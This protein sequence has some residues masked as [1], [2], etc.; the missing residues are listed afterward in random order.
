MGWGVGDVVHAR[1]R[2]LSVLGEGGMGRVWRARDLVLDREVAIKELLLSG[3]RLPGG[4]E[5]ELRTR[6]LREARSAAQLKHPGVITVHDVIDHEGDPLIVM[7]LIDG[8]SLAALLRAKG[9]LPAPRVAEI[10]TALLDALRAAHAHGIFH[11]DVKPSNV[12]FE[13]DRI[14]LT[15]FGIAFHPEDGRITRDGALLGTPAFMAPEQASGSPP[16]AAADLWSLGATLYHAV[17]GRPPVRGAQVM[18]ILSALSAPGEVPL[19]R[20]QMPE[21]LRALLVGLLRKD[22]AERITAAQASRLLEQAGGRRPPAPPAGTVPLPPP[23]AKRPGLPRWRGPLLSVGGIA[24]VV[25]LTFMLANVLPHDEPTARKQVPMQFALRLK[26][27]LRSKVFAPIAFSPSEETPLLAA[28]DGTEVRL[29]RL[30]D[31]EDFKLRPA[32]T[33]EYQGLAFDPSGRVLAAFGDDTDARVWDIANRTELGTFT[34]HD[35]SIDLGILGEGGAAVT[36]DV[37]D[38]A[39][40]WNWGTVLQTAN[41]DP[42]G[43]LLAVTLQG[44]ETAWA[45]FQD[46][47]DTV[48]IWDLASSTLVSRLRGHQDSVEKAEFSPDGKII[49]TASDDRTTRIWETGTGQ[50]WHELKT[51]ETV[52]LIRF[53]KDGSQFAT[54]GDTSDDARLWSVGG[55]E[56]R[57]RLSGHRKEILDLAFSPDG[58]TIATASHDK[59]VLLWEADSGEVTQRLAEYTSYVLDVE[60]S[61]DGRRLAAVDRDGNLTIWESV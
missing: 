1:Y 14:I 10:G 33:A 34:K 11:R 28:G 35:G 60:F 43:R 7:E 24:A 45:A 46:K 44:N 12:L 37:N 31:Y 40:L 38:S 55:E 5:H 30:D 48:A 15:D 6:T 58:S 18:E 22:P 20:A 61:R 2:L 32:G 19:P 3:R 25:L 4:L 13:G 41:V 26:T 27:D 29:W 56:A 36:G 39:R 8:R 49:V 16:S 53:N 23:P 17:E 51:P 47:G 52:S 42:G 57:F 50:E 9:P 54:V 21:P 59:T